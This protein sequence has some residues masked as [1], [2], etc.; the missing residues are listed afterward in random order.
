M[1][2]KLEWTTLKKNIQK[3]PRDSHKGLFGHVVIIGSDYGFFGATQMA[4]I[5]ALRIGTG[6]VSVATREELAL[7]TLH[8]EV[9]THGIRFAK[10]IKK[11][12]S[13]A[14]VVVIGPGLGQSLWA[15]QLLKETLKIQKPMIV[16]ADALNLLSHKPQKNARWI[17][18]PHVGEAARLLKTTPEDIQKNRPQAVQDIQKKFGGI[19]ILK[20]HGTLIANGEKV[21]RCDA[22]NPGMSTAGMGDILSGVLGG[23]AAQGYEWHAVAE[24]GVMVH[25]RAADLAAKEGGERGMIATDL[26][27]FL[28]QLMNES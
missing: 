6:L 21:T 3:R 16:D 13:R 17:L 12:L 18:T 19:V 1:I 20:G 22:G 15:K 11:L 4:A 27:P 23:L 26:L 25:A 8:P 9:M 28:R 24:L 7:Q 5:A 10:D 2:E 14:T